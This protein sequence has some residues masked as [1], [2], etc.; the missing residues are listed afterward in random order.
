ML[1]CIVA[2]DIPNSIPKRHAARQRHVEH[3]NTLIADGRLV[4]AGPH[5][6]IDSPEPGPAGM[7][8]SL[9]VAEFNSLE[10]AKN[11]AAHDPYS[12]EGVF[13]RVEVRPFLQ[14]FP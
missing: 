4:I 9:I 5:P 7:C 10:D 14:V 3:L 13:E 12:L 1:Y 11:W 2:T 6:A 8:G